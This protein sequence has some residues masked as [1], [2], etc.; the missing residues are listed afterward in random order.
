MWTIT[1]CARKPRNNELK[2]ITD[3]HNIT[4]LSY[5]MRC[6]FISDKRQGDSFFLLKCVCDNKLLLKRAM[7]VSIP[8]ATVNAQ[9]GWRLMK[10]N[11]TKLK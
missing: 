3:V 6:C 4:K 8:S 1:Q 5:D 2:Y 9:I 7:L 11:K 10:K